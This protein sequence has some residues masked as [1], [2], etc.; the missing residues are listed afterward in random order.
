MNVS[1]TVSGALDFVLINEFDSVEQSKLIAEMTKNGLTPAQTEAHF[2]GLLRLGLILCREVVIT[3]SMLLDGAFFQMVGPRELEHRLGLSGQSLGIRVLSA[4]PTLREALDAKK[5][6]QDF[7]W[8]LDRAGE[9]TF[10][11]PSVE[12]RW[13]EWVDAETRGALSIRPFAQRPEGSFSRVLGQL[14]SEPARIR[15]LE[16][17]VPSDVIR[18]T[19]TFHTKRSQAFA[20]FDALDSRQGDIPRLREWW[21]QNYLEAIAREQGAAW[22]SFQGGHKKSGQKSFLLWDALLNRVVEASPAVYS[23]MFFALRHERKKWH[24]ALTSGHQ[25]GRHLRGNQA[26]RGIAYIA[27]NHLAAS[28]RSNVAIRALFTL[29]LGAIGFFLAR[30]DADKRP[31]LS[32]VVIAVALAALPWH[33]VRT[34]ISALKTGRRGVLKIA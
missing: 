2:V 16:A 21:N 17:A 26:L 24:D 4:H 14:L 7:V 32:W 22:M 10:P 8:Q 29:V 12:A 11:A 31:E 19:Q 28:G 3:D 34:L 23:T 33:E 6:D 9:S 13:Q 18:T 30:V 20:Y 1:S 27:A 15:E 25:A 5:A